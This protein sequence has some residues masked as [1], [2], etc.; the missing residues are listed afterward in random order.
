MTDCVLY[1]GHSSKKTDF[2]HGDQRPILNFAPRGKL[3]P[4]GAKLS[5]RRQFLTSPLRAN[6]DPR[7]EVVPRGRSCHPGMNFV[8]LWW[9]YPLGENFSETVQCSP[10]GVNKGVNIPP[11]RQ[12]SPLGA[13]FTPRGKLYP[14]G[15]TIL[16]KTGLWGGKFL[17]NGRLFTLVSSWATYF[18]GTS[19]VLVWF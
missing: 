9:I 3:W 2:M 10:L 4:P 6:F 18:H 16:Q 1:C 12:G 8:P 15:Q 17:P 14:W 7:G 11:R 5:P 13:K 19:Y